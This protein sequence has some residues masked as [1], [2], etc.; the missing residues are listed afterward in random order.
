[1]GRHYDF[2]SSLVSVVKETQKS[3]P[4]K[5]SQLEKDVEFGGVDVTG[6]E[7]GQ[8][9]KVAEVD[10]NGK[11]TAWAPV[12]LPEQAQADWNQNDEGAADYVKNRPFYAGDLS[13]KE[14]FD[15]CALV[16]A[17]GSSWVDNSDGSFVTG[18]E[19]NGCKLVFDT[20][21]VIGDKYSIQ[22]NGSTYECT[23]V[24]GSDIFGDPG[25]IIIGDIDGLLSGN[26]TYGVIIMVTP[27]IMIDD[28]DTSGRY[29]IL[30][31]ADYNG[32]APTE[33]TVIGQKQEIVKIDPK[34][35]AETDPTV[36]DWAKQDTKPTYTL[37]EIQGAKQKD[38]I[39]GFD[40]PDVEVNGCT[41]ESDLS[42]TTESVDIINNAYRNGSTFYAKYNHTL[43]PMTYVDYSMVGN[44]KVKFVDTIKF[45]YTEVNKTAIVFR[46][47]LFTNNYR[48]MSAILTIRRFEV[49]YS[50]S[51]SS[52]NP[53]MNSIVTTKL[54]E[55][56]SQIDDI[57]GDGLE[58]DS[59]GAVNVTWIINSSTEGSSKKF[60]LSVDDSG[61]ISATEIGQ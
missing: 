8:I 49:D 53:V 36:P 45:S 4:T 10:E 44:N 18:Y 39:I 6:A 28:S 41:L 50:L 46:E 26:I 60:K 34:F 27:Y 52:N 56:Q 23:A 24:D 37:N 51:S 21:L 29:C 12:D 58:K 19:V 11:P 40:I 13:E 55:L 43:I 7:V 2:L 35:I 14:L 48:K 59:T 15:V 54:K 16:E 22:H 57:P 38:F 17:S 61:T 25:S 9:I 20:P 42:K 30:F 31:A 5:M 32:S 33:L 1:M 3:I 47:L